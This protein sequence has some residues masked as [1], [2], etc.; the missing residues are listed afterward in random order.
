MHDPG[1]RIHASV[2]DTKLSTNKQHTL[3]HL[4]AYSFV[5]Y[6]ARTL[7][8]AAEEKRFPL[9]PPPPLCNMVPY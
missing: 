1:W 3:S 7:M 2:E 6:G 5:F 4:F 8:Y 9:P